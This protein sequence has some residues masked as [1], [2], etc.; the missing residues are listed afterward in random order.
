ML[1][2]FFAMITITQLIYIR[3]GQED[4]F[5][6]FEAIAIPLITKYRGRLL[7]RVRPARSAVIEASIESPYE[8]H[9][10]EFPEEEDLNAFMQDDSRQSFLHLKDQSI[11]SAVLIKGSRILG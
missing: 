5:D 8:I 11:Q 10:V 4:T 9:L 3:G 2:I 6:K 1:L 7:L